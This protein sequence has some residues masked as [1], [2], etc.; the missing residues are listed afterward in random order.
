M[1]NYDVFM[2]IV[3]IVAT[4]W[5][6]YKGLAWQVASISALVVSYIAAYRFRA[7]V[8]PAMPV[9]APFNLLLA[10]LVIFLVCNLAIW[11]LFRLIKSFMDRLKLREFDHQ[12]GALLGLA[13]G[14]LLCVL[15]T[16]FAMTFGRE[17]HR[18]TII[19]SRSGYY[20]S[21]LLSQSHPWIPS[22]VREIVLPY[23]ENFQQQMR[24]AGR[25]DGAAPPA[26]DSQRVPSPGWYRSARP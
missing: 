25:G 5:G 20:I 19:Q 22:E 7:Q 2:L 6:A 17:N 12:T 26:G 9:G 14:V 3:L 10:M 13:K 21:W 11:I 16:L 4:L 23:V 8:A 24:A 1:E 18:R 15:I